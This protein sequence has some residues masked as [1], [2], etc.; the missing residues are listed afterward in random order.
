MILGSVRDLNNSGTIGVVPMTDLMLNLGAHLGNLGMTSQNIAWRLLKIH[1]LR[2]LVRSDCSP[3]PLVGLADSLEDLSEVYQ[4]QLQHGAA[5]TASQQSIDLW[6]HLSESFPEID[7]R[8]SFLSTLVKHAE[9]LLETG[10]KMAALSSVEEAVVL[11][12]P[13][14]EQICGS[15]SR[16]PSLTKEDEYCT[17]LY[18]SN[19]PRCVTK[20]LGYDVAT[21]CLIWHRTCLKRQVRPRR[22]EKFSNLV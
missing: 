3:G 22:A 1:F 15:S 10:Q 20:I 16:L 6:R 8:T 19:C 4:D 13:I 5:L 11:C 18:G 21:A 7:N 14:A 12:R 17:D 2:P 9:N